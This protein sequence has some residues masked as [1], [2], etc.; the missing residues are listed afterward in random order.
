[1]ASRKFYLKGIV[2][3]DDSIESCRN[4]GEGCEYKFTWQLFQ[5]VI[6]NFDW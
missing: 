2:I 5:N 3:I 6:D 1:L 4:I